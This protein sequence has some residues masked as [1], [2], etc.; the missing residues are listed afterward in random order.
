[1]GVFVRI[2]SLNSLTD[3]IELVRQYLI[4]GWVLVSGGCVSE[5]LEKLPGGEDVAGVVVVYECGYVIHILMFRRD[6]LRSVLEDCVSSRDLEGLVAL[7]L[8][9]KSGECYARL[10][11]PGNPSERNVFIEEFLNALAEYLE[12]DEVERCVDLTVI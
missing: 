1:V 10:I 11:G 3:V 12:R 8:F 7:E 5:F 2:I 9:V 4:N 6:V